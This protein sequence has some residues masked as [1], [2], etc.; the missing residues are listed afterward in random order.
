M[1]RLPVTWDKTLFCQLPPQFRMSF[2]LISDLIVMA[3]MVTPQGSK[4]L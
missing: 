3:V 4:F 2:V 1:Q